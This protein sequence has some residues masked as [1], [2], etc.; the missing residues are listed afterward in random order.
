MSRIFTRKAAAVAGAATLALAL[1]ACTPP[2]ENPSDLKVDTA[3]EFQAPAGEADSSSSVVSSSEVA[4]PG[5]TEPGVGEPTEAET[6]TG[7][8]DP[9]VGEAPVTPAQPTATFTG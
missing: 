1:A 6:G 5:M 3:T 9:A 8:E 4:E 7:V 2:N